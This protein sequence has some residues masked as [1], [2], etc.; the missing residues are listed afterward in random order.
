MLKFSYAR[1]SRRWF[2]EGY[3]VL[4]INVGWCSSCF[5]A[6]AWKK[7]VI[8]MLTYFGKTGP[9]AL[10]FFRRDGEMHARG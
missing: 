1:G 6:S 5:Q 7:Y 10:S 3:L 9:W 8:I 2:V 4:G